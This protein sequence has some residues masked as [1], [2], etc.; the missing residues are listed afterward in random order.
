MIRDRRHPIARNVP[1]S[2]VRSKTDIIIVFNMPM[3]PM[4]SAMAEV[5]QATAPLILICCTLF[6]NSFDLFHFQP[7]LQLQNTLG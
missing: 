1:I 5:I 2:L 7:R 6:T 4:I 3:A